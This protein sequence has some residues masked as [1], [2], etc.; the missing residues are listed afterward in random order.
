MINSIDIV[1]RYYFS[2]RQYIYPYVFIRLSVHLSP[3]TLVV[4]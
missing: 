3:V 1:V 4:Y 2:V